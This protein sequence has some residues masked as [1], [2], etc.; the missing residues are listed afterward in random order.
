MVRNLPEMDLQIYTSPVRFLWFGI[1]SLMF[2][3]VGWWMIREATEP[4]ESLIGWIML[5]LFGLGAVVFF[6]RALQGRQLLLAVGPQ[7]MWVNQSSVLLETK[8]VLIPWE[9]I[10]GVTMRETWVRWTRLVEL[11]VGLKNPARIMQQL[12]LADTT[13]KR[14]LAGIVGNTLTISLA[15]QVPRARKQ[16]KRVVKLA[17]RYLTAGH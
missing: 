15:G 14:L 17:Q 10:T 1:L 4:R 3:A 7:G 11:K 9:E 8:G 6:R 13:G 16:A 12:G 5:V 2:A